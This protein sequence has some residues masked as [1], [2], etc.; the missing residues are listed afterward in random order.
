MSGVA[1]ANP[2]RSV[3]PARLDRLPW[4][5]FHTRL[6]VAL[7]ITWTLDGLEIT[8]SSLI[9]GILQSPDTL[10]LSSAGIGRAATA[11]LLGEVVGALG[12]GYLADRL[13]RRRLFI[14][15]LAVYLA[16]NAVTVFAFD[17]WSL[18]VCRFVAGAGIG[19]EVAAINSAIDELI[20][21]NYRGR[22]DIALNGTYWLG[23]LIATLIATVLLNP[24]VLPIDV[25]WRVA[26]LTGPVIGVMIWPLRRYLPESP[27]W[28]LTH[29][30]REA[31]ETTVCD[32]ERLVE[33]RGHRLLPIEECEPCVVTPARAIG[34]R[35]LARV[36]LRTYPERAL[37]GFALMA[38]QSFL[39]N[40]IFFTYGLVLT[41]F[42]AVDASDVP[43]YFYAFAFGNLLGPFVLGRFFDTVGR[44]QMITGTYVLAGFLLLVSALLFE[45]GVLTAYTQTLCWCA[46]FFV[47]SA[48]ASAA[49]LTVSEIFPL[50]I[51]AQAIAFFF[52][53]AQLVGST[54]P[55]LFGSLIGDEAN[56]DRSWLAGGYVLAA[57]MMI[58]AGLIE[59]K[60][61]VRAERASL[62]SLCRSDPS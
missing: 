57:A 6:V 39:Y 40:A 30:Q 45:A 36:L 10:G 22:T 62:E 18:A 43:R 3:I 55:W 50:E 42:Y 41:H 28:L 4:S 49:Y 44:R 15:T 53:A 60:W 33:A 25:G 27:R 7:G 58:G 54:G 37:L 38:S 52:A 51:R 2:E 26:L 56:P 47:A 13:G 21:A 29:G 8:F 32:I 61:G 35:T 16:A 59:A 14:A 31:A 1:A 46:I 17:L 23:A 34:Y 24:E 11:Y 9:A 19:G 48:A 20:P 12:F 5:S